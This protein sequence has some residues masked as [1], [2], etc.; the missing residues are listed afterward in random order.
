MKLHRRI[1]PYPKL[2]FQ[3]LE[4]SKWPPLP[5]KPMKCTKIKISFCEKTAGPN[6]S[7]LG[8]ITPRTEYYYFMEKNCYRLL[9][10]KQEKGG[11]VL[12]APKWDETSWKL[13]RISRNLVILLPGRST[14]DLC[15]KNA[16]GWYHGNKKGG[17]IQSASKWMKLHRNDF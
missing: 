9:P 12:S 11:K 17:K 1:E 3:G 14:F 16:I 4:F 15:K 13:G 5:W 8:K 7:I 6:Y 10:W 2:C